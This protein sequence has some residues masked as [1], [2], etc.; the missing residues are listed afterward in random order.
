MALSPADFKAAL[1]RFASGVTVVTLRD[2]DAGPDGDAGHHG[3]TASAFCSLSL[4]PPLVLVCVGNRGDTHARLLRADGFAINILND[5]QVDVSN[6]FA[7]WGS[8]GGSPWDGLSF[9]LGAVSGARLI[10]GSLATLDCKRWNRLDGGDHSI[11]I[12]EVHATTLRGET[13]RDEAQSELSPL[14]YFSG[15]YRTV[16]TAP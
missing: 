13:L 16:G 4:D 5:A 7:G 2:P 8:P 14:L 3:M 1:G 9:Q 12:G 6:R 15:R 11:F 10:D